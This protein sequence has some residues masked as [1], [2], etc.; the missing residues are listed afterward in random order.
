MDGYPGMD[1]YMKSNLEDTVII[2]HDC[3]TGLYPKDYNCKHVVKYDDIL[4]KNNNDTIT[5]IADCHLYLNISLISLSN[6]D[7][8]IGYKVYES[9]LSKLILLKSLNM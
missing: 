3:T 5:F 7:S 8:N 9:L 1:V 2:Q 4:Y 6:E